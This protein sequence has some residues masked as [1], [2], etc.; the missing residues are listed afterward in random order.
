MAREPLIMMSMMTMMVMSTLLSMLLYSPT[1]PCCT[2]LHSPSTAASSHYPSTTTL[3]SLGKTE[4]LDGGW[5]RWGW[6]YWAG[7][8]TNWVQNLTVGTTAHKVCDLLLNKRFQVFWYIFVWVLLLLLR[9]FLVSWYPISQ[10][11]AT[12]VTYLSDRLESVKRHR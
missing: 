9:C 5:A 12:T 7:L 3:A 11:M 2:T 10:N 8:D 6:N 4:R 1:I